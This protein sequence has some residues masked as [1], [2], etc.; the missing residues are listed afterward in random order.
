M[1]CEEE[2]N[3]E[4]A[5]LQSVLEF[6][7]IRNERIQAVFSVIYTI[8]PNKLLKAV[9]GPPGRTAVIV[10][11]CGESVGRFATQVS[12]SL[13]RRTSSI[14]AALCKISKIS[15]RVL[16]DEMARDTSRNEH[17]A[18]CDER[19]VKCVLLRV[20][21]LRTEAFAKSRAV[22]GLCARAFAWNAN[23]PI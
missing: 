16:S 20:R 1:C 6:G 17:S 19:H 14:F 8:C 12:L 2:L 23:S 3:E 13:Q 22:N 10:V 4:L 21:R 15:V 11:R 9:A 5:N 7:V 18:Q